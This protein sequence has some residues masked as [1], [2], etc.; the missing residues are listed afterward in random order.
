MSELPQTE[1]IQIGG[2]DDFELDV[3]HYLRKEYGDIGEAALEIPAII[4]WVNSKLQAIVERKHIVKH[5][6][7]EREAAAFFDLRDQSAFNAAGFPGKPTDSAVERAVCLQESV[8]ESYSEFAVL[9][10]WSM[11]L[12]NLIMELQL[13][14]ELTRS[15]E[16]TR[17]NLIGNSQDD[18]T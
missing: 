6:I 18:E 15:T 10:G 11:R 3:D 1:K 16:A 7:K 12:S 17:R 4:E 14:M 9:N 5:Q 13:K 8:V 2:V